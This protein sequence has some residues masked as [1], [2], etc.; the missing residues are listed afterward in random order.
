MPVSSKMPVITD[1]L[2]ITKIYL[3]RAQKV[4]LDFDLAKLYATEAKRLK[5]A[6]RRNI[7]RFPEDF[8]FQL[9]QG[10]YENLRTQIASS[11]WGGPR[12]MPYAFTESR[13]MRDF[14]AY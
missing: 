6:V 14:P 7:E 13:H 11:S 4:M 9:T 8:M 5:A 2:V 12:Y 3:I 10:E 1:E